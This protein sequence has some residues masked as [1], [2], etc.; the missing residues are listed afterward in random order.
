[1]SYA[2]KQVGDSCEQRIRLSWER[3][4]RTGQM[5]GRSYLKGTEMSSDKGDRMVK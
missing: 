1:M 4:G 3:E 2:C 5:L